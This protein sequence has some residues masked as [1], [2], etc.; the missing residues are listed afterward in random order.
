MLT[1][2]LNESDIIYIAAYPRKKKLQKKQT[3]QKIVESFASFEF[4]MGFFL[5]GKA[6]SHLLLSI[7]DTYANMAATLIGSFRDAPGLSLCASAEIGRSYGLEVS[8][9]SA[10]QST[11]GLATKHWMMASLVLVELVR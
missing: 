1:T 3:C 5:P 9:R 10:V 8:C 7:F 6:Q 11:V 4:A 2:I